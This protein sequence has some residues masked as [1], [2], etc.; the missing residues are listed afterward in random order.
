MLV[1]KKK[2]EGRRGLKETVA[3]YQLCSPEKGALIEDLARVISKPLPFI[4][5]LIYKIG[6]DDKL[7]QFQVQCILQLYIHSM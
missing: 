5:K 6:R 1:V 7:G 4:D 2:G 3:A